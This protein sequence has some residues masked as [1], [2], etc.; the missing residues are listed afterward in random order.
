MG[1]SF[2]FSCAAKNENSLL[3][4]KRHGVPARARGR[5][6]AQVEVVKE[7]RGLRRGR[8]GRGARGA[9][10]SRG[11]LLLCLLLCLLLLLA[12]AAAAAVGSC[13]PAAA[14][15]LLGPLRRGLERRGVRGQRVPLRLGRGELREEARGAGLALL[16]VVVVL[17]WFEGKREKEVESSQKGKGL[18]IAV[19]DLRAASSWRGA[20]RA[21]LR[22]RKLPPFPTRQLALSVSLSPARP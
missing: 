15:A 1:E 20:P 11:L 6:G 4:S 22:E 2:L 19:I 21:D 9:Q 5:R 16:V 8:R 7:E 14:A 12:S 3:L 18:V 17:G 10:R 13:S